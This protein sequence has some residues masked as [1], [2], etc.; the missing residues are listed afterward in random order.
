[1]IADL[2]RGSTIHDRR[3]EAFHLPFTIYDQ[4]ST[5]LFSFYF[6]LHPFSLHRGGSV[7]GAGFRYG[8]KAL[9]Q[10]WRPVSVRLTGAF[11]TVAAACPNLAEL[12]GSEAS[13]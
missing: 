11:Q 7:G 12:G 4:R 1:M 13:S 5:I 9:Q 10:P 2:K 8:G 6:R 3:S